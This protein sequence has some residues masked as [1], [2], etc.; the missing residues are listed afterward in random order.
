MLGMIVACTQ[1]LAELLARV[2][3][4]SFVSLNLDGVTQRSRE[5]VLVTV[6]AFALAGLLEDLLSPKRPGGHFSV[7]RL[8]SSAAVAR[9]IVVSLAAGL[10]TVAYLWEDELGSRDALIDVALVMLCANA[11]IVLN[12]K[13]ARSAKTALV[14]MALTMLA[15]GRSPY[16]A[17]ISVVAGSTTVLGVGELVGRLTLGSA[18]AGSIGAAVGVG[19]AMVSP[20]SISVLVALL[21]ALVA[22][23]AET[24]RLEAL[25][26]DGPLETFDRLGR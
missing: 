17:G 1:V 18:G 22:W 16:L 24:G 6:V 3:S 4:D 20:S 21:A 25:F 12:Q 10:S 13:P 2:I 11:F 14:A 26:A 15:S 8:Q 9:R 7:A 19:V 5:V 23:L